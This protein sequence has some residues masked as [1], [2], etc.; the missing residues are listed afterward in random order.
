MSLSSSPESLL[1]LL[2]QLLMVA[3]IIT[4]TDLFPVSLSV[5]LKL[6][7]AVRETQKSHIFKP[8]VARVGLNNRRCLY[9]TVSD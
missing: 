5:I 2:L 1:L 8:I 4:F 6:M 3:S 7:Y 9:C